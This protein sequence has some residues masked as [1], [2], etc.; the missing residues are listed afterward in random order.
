MWNYLILLTE[1]FQSSSKEK[2]PFENRKRNGWIK[3][4]ILFQFNLINYR[5]TKILSVLE[6][7]NAEAD[8]CTPEY[9]PPERA[10]LD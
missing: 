9:T 1:I 6:F 8:F 10:P 7:A 4:Q 2:N 3:L 5:S